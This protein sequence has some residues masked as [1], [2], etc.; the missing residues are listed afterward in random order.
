MSTDYLNF[1][2][3]GFLNLN[4]LYA[5]LLKRSDDYWEE[6]MFTKNLIA[7]MDTNNDGVLDFEVNGFISM[8]V[9]F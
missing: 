1:L 6:V 3:L 7:S 9:F 5:A 4:K 2:F 8:L